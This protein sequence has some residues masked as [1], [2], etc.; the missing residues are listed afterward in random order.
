M[1]NITS[2][3]NK[4]IIKFQ[5]IKTNPNQKLIPNYSDPTPYARMKS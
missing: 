5:I 1:D 3:S 2:L 4:I